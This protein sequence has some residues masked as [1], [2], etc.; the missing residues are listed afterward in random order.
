H[1]TWPAAV[2]LAVS[3]MLVLLGLAGASQ[4]SDSTGDEILYDA[5]LAAGGVVFYG[6]MIAV[7]FAIAHAYPRRMDALGFRPFRLRWVWIAFAVVVATTVVAVAVEPFLHGGEDQG[8]GADRWEPEHA[9]AFVANVAVLVLLGPFAEEL[10]FRGL[11]V[12]VLAQ[13]G[14]LVAILVTGVIFGLVH[15]IL[16]ALP[17]LVLF[18]IGLAWVR[19]RSASVWPTFIGHAAYN[20]LGILVLVLS[21][22]ADS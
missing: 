19:L 11:G 22:T 8:L 7:S 18:G 1:K 10:F 4:G 14:G 16:G 2:W 20:G 21:W 13:Y 6:S 15:G 12:R 5:D 3:S 9:E 17:P